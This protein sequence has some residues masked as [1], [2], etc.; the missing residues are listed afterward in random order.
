MNGSRGRVWYSLCRQAGLDSRTMSYCTPE[1]FHTVYPQRP[2]TRIDVIDYPGRGHGNLELVTGKTE[3]AMKWRGSPLCVKG[4]TTPKVMSVLDPL[5]LMKDSAYLPAVTSDLIKGMTV[6]PQRYT[7]KPTVDEVANFY[8]EE[9]TFDIETAYPRR[10]ITVVGISKTPYEVLVV[11]FKPAYIP[12]LRRIFASAKTVV[13]QNIIGFDLPA[14]ADNGIFIDKSAQI[15]DTMLMHHLVQPD[16]P[17]DLEF[18]A[19]I[20]TQMVAWKHLSHAEPE[21]YNACDVD[22]ALQSFRELKTQLDLCDLT[23]LYNYLQVPLA[24]I[25][26]G[27]KDGGIACDPKRAAERRDQCEQEL[28]KLERQLPD[29]LQSYDK[30]IRIRKSAPAG[31]LG[32]SGKPAKYIFEPGT[33]R[34]TPWASPKQIEKWL[35]TDLKLPKQYHRK[36]KK[37]STDKISL[38]KLAKLSAG[39]SESIQINALQKLRSL[40][41]LLSTFYK[42]TESD[43]P[44]EIVHANFL[45][46]GTATGRLSS[47]GPNMQNIPMDARYLYVPSRADYCFVEA[48]F[49][50]LENRLAAWYA[51]D[52]DRLGR[53]STAGF[54][55]HLWLAQQIY[56]PQVTKA[57]KE[58]KLGKITNHGADGAMGSNMLA[59]THGLE[60]KVAR[61]LIEQWRII[62]K[63]S[64]AWQDRVGNEATSKGVLTNAFGRKRWF[65]SHSAYTEGIRFLPQSTGADICF[66]SMVALCYKNI[67]WSE[68]ATLKVSSVLAPLPLGARLVLQVHDSLL[69]ECPFSVREEVVDCMSKAMT[70]SWP[71]LGGFSIPVEFKV[72]EPGMAWGELVSLK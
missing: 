34:I 64:A 43:R 40:E 17:H 31:T 57:D 38:A 13:G 25:C 18:I 46:H 61:H 23:N 56:G 16:C 32:K 9:L 1:D 19:S 4:E 24:R 55:E 10:D 26:K 37:L 39:K 41:E 36:S 29:N 47:S 70:Q 65:F 42:E 7:L 5:Y 30:R 11:P 28:N 63:V 72:G 68:E 33:K 53:L 60:P 35:Y 67:G 62:N 27:M 50:S 20:C 51:N 21:Y 52:V 45:V 59:Q 8:A 15:W 3:G 69:V 48:D 44:I 2:W 6:P 22:A 71:Q 66:R 58:Y 14:L 54:N 12:H 49:S